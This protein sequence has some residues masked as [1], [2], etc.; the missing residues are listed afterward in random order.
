VTR[1]R[2][3]SALLAM[4]AVAVAGVALATCSV[5]RG[6]YTDAVYACDIRQTDTARECGDGWACHA[7]SQLGTF[8]FCA[9]ACAPGG[10]AQYCGPDGALLET[11]DPSAP[12]CGT[13]MQCLRTSVT[14]NQGLC[15]PV[16]VCGR[17]DE[18]RDPLRSRCLA[19]VLMDLYGAE[20]QAEMV[21]NMWCLQGDCN[22]L[23]PCEAGH[24]CLG[25]LSLLQKIPPVCVPNCGRSGRDDGGLAHNDLC[26]R[27]FVCASEVLAA[28]PYRFCLPGLL[29]FPCETDDHCLV[30]T[31]LGVSKVAAGT[32][33]KRGADYAFNLNLI[34]IASARVESRIFK[35]VSGGMAGLVATLQEAARQLL[36]PK[37]EPGA[38]KIATPAAAGAR[39]YVDDAFI[40][41]TPVKSGNLE[42]GRHRLR[43]EKD[44]FHEWRRE[45]AVPAGTTLD[46]DLQLDQMPPR[47]VWPTYVAWMALGSAVITAATGTFF[48]V[49]SQENPSGSS[50][51]LLL[52]DVD[53]KAGQ[54]RTATILFGVSGAFAVTSAVV[55]IVCWKDIFGRRERSRQASATPRLRL[56]AAPLAG[57]AAASGVV[58]F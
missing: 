16:D 1:R 14:A 3:L 55:F 18:C 8:D 52:Q 32:I 38:V 15:L 37:A 48:G 4:L 35:M 50:R 57:G 22:D 43:V 39:V 41:T 9:P 40:G 36:Q 11:C 49:L 19:K 17:D 7:G 44:G 24:S 51:A 45:V 6:R 26:P 42:A 27:S 23:S 21:N 31:S 28:L 33:G 5:D 12:A 46:L 53:K 34:D 10:E 56:M 25:G 47:R 20:L 58:T 54:A 29:G 13:D 30:G 2:S